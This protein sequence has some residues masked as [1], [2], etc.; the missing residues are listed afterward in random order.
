MDLIVILAWIPFL[1]MIGLGTYLLFNIKTAESLSGS[2]TEELVTTIIA[3]N[4]ALMPPN[5]YL[6]GGDPEEKANF[7][8]AV[9]DFE[10]NLESFSEH[11]HSPEERRLY[12]EIKSRWPRLKRLAAEILNLKNPQGSKQG[13]KLMEEMDAIGDEISKALESLSSHIFEEMHH[14]YDRLKKLSFEGVLGI[15]LIAFM[16]TI[17]RSIILFQLGFFYKKVAHFMDSLAQNQDLTQTPKARIICQ[18]QKIFLFFEENS[19]V[20]LWLCY[21]PEASLYQSL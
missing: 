9:Q 7:A 18:E 6:I 4:E 12:Q 1:I 19:K 2:R 11:I 3:L 20:L 21:P 16:A 17:I 15:V 14:R 10:K 8:K 13:Y 5:D